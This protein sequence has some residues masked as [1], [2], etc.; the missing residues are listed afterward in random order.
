MVN[1]MEPDEQK[2]VN[3][4]AITYGIYHLTAVGMS[5]TKAMDALVDE[6][7]ELG[8]FYAAAMMAAYSL[9]VAEAVVEGMEC[10]E[11]MV[12]ID[13]L[14]CFQQVTEA[15]E[16]PS[17]KAAFAWSAQM[18]NTAA[19][20]NRGLLDTLAAVLPDDED[21]QRIWL[22]GHIANCEHWIGVHGSPKHAGEAITNYESDRRIPWRT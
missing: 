4:S 15:L 13:R 11:Y 16:V 22:N 2:M 12:L 1:T 6:A 14:G 21:Q 9:R 18:F 20:Q 17:D 7:I 8:T 5:G 3:A 19:E 10:P